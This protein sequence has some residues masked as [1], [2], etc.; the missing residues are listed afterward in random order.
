MADKKKGYLRLLLQVLSRF[1]ICACI[2]TSRARTGSS[3]TISS[4]VDCQRPG[5]AD[6]LFCPPLNSWGI[7]IPESGA[8]PTHFRG[9]RRHA[10]APPLVREAVNQQWLADGIINGPPGSRED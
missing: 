2:E 3:A 9:Y 1:S 8:S 7:S 5:D 4:G 6:A 10:S